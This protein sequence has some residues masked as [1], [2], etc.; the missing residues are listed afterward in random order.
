MAQSISF[1]QA[2]ELAKSGDAEAQYALSSVLHQRRQFDESVHWLRL[3][4]AQGFAPAQVTLA[5]FL[6]DGR[7]CPRDRQ[8]A[9]ELLQPLAAADVQANLLLAE[10]EGYAALGATGRVAGLRHLLAAA[11]LGD[12][13]SLRQ[14]ALLSV[15]HRR[16][17]LVRPLLDAAARR[18]DAAA[19]Y[20]LASAYAWGFG[21][22]PQPAFAA[23]ICLGEAARRQY[24]GPS[25]Q[26]ALREKGLASAVD[27]PPALSIDWSLLEQ[28]L[29]QL[30]A[31]LPLRHTKVLNEEPLIRIFH[32]LIH[33]LV[34]D[35]LINLAAPLVQRSQIV[36]AQTG[37]ARA[38]PMRNSSHVTLGPRQH[39]HVV[40]AVE[41]CLGRITGLP[42]LHG[43]FLQVLR[44]RQG[45]EFRPHVDY[46]NESGAGSYKSLADGGQ[47]AQTVLTYLNQDYRGGSTAFPQLKLDIKGRRGD[48]LHFHNLGPDGLGHR[49]TLHAGM[50]VLEGE[51]WLLSQWIRSERY[52][53][54]VAW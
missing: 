16:Q 25:L 34:L 33:P 18:S 46:F 40:E 19:A 54:R 1:Q 39:D 5:T 26:Q 48:V 45:E 20:L 44:Y 21:G 53:A 24:L 43:E 41:A 47:R 50:P 36:D 13:G 15:L 23:A 37:V 11:R 27:K 10:V 42:S 38:D 2:T 52:P 28:A 51:K 35:A 7:V 8:Q 14:L 6:I 4:A 29:P 12:A 22:L 9:I 3:A 49:D 32:D 30:A 17:D 31:D